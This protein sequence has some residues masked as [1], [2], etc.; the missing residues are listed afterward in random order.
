MFPG[1]ELKLMRIRDGMLG[2]Y[3]KEKL[4]LEGLRL[5]PKP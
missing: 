1:R 4:L 3:F 5:E 2:K